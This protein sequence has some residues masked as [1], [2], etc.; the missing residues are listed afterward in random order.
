ME[1]V[2]RVA[3]I[4]LFI[5]ICLRALGK[6]DFSELS[7]FDLVTLLLIPEIVQESIVR[8]D[9]SITNAVIGL[10]TLFSLVLIISIITHKNKRVGSIIEGNPTVLVSNGQFV[11]DN[12]NRERISSNEV[13]SEM[14]KSGLAKIEQVRWAI[15]E[16]DGR[17]SF[18]PVAPDDKQIKPKPQRAIG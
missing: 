11:E 15:L 3:L 6:R 7:P 4:Y 5:L 18:I 2:L 17:I 1:T 13:Y 8:E 9:Y 16:P 10:S 14:H 12:M